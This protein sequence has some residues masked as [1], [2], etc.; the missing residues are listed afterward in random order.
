MPIAPKKDLIYYLISLRFMKIPVWL[1]TFLY[2][3]RRKTEK[4]LFP[5][6]KTDYKKYWE[7]RY[8]KGGTSGSGSYGKLAEYKADVINNFI[9]ENKIR[10]II[11]FGCGDGNQLKLMHYGKYVGLDIS[12]SAIDRC[13]I[14]F[15]EDK[16]KSFRT[17]APGK[18]ENIKADLVVCLDVLYHILDYGDYMQ[19]LKDIAGASKRYIILYTSTFAQENSKSGHIKRRDVIS[20]LNEIKGIRILKITKNKY[21]KESDSDFIFIEK[22]P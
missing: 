3:I 1:N 13:K 12:K 4:M 8:K 17:Y 2:R 6:K 22:V 18:P 11:E 14:T 16:T 5:D 20:D 15:A 19:T 7:D 9:K 21:P 10:S